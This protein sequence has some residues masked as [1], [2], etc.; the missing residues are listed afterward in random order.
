MDSKLLLVKSITLLYKEST[1]ADANENSAPLIR[2]V[3]ATIRLPESI[4][5]T[6]PGRATIIA[7]KSTALWMCDN[8]PS[9]QYDRGILLQRI[10][11]NVGDDESLYLAF[12]AGMTEEP[13]LDLVKRAC[14]EHRGGLR[15]YIDQGLVENILKQAADKVRFNK[16]TIDWRNFVQ[17]VMTNLEPLSSSVVEV[18]REGMVDEVDMDDDE[19]IALLMTQAKDDTSSVGVMRC[20]WQ[21]VNRMLGDHN[22]FR[23]GEC[24]VVPALQFNFKTGF[25]LNLFRQLTRYNKPLMIDP[26]KKPML[27]HISTENSLTDNMMAI[28]IQLMENETGQACD[29]R[30]IDVGVASKYVKEKLQ[31]M[32]YTVSMCRMNPSDV[33][34]NTICDRITYYESL[35]YEIHGLVFDYLNMISKKGCT[36]GGPTGAD[37]RDLYRRVR[38]F[39]SAR[40]ILFITPHQLSTEAKMLVRQGVENFV[41]E[42]ANKGYYD[43]C[44]TVDQEVDLEIYIHIVKVNG[45]SY[46][47]IQRGKHRKVSV[48]PDADLYC[49]YKF[50]EVAAIPD[51]VDGRDMSRK[52]A[53]GGVIGSADEKPW[54]ADS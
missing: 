37:I 15:A 46:L 26:K 41:Q 30:G 22:G 5:E 14:V 1:L 40:K 36:V 17:D 50:E 6:D 42:I 11:V 24:V 48:T 4:M 20:G 28:Y 35:G 45:V 10:R 19:K 18:K 23:R 8:P 53:G 51:D 43:G 7:L 47:T 21:G 52:H 16:E 29:I 33:T 38:N 3:I 2:S 34:Y 54:F 9:H 12:L 25:T 39:T 49:V 27:M 13:D 44:R 31:E 32:G